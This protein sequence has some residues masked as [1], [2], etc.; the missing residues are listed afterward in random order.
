MP[1]LAFLSILP[2]RFPT[3]D[4]FFY[5]FFYNP[6]FF[7]VLSLL[8]CIP[9][10]TTSAER[11]KVI[12]YIRKL[13]QQKKT[14]FLFPEGEIIKEKNVKQLKQGI[15]FFIKDASMVM[16]VRFHGLNKT[17]REGV[18]RRISFGEV[19]EPPP[20]MTVDGM[21]AYLEDL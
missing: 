18:S 4:S 2:I 21:R 3:H 6:R 11:M 7:P 13:L 17:F 15:D 10:G 12:F 14:V 9:V 1:F 5:S 19:F 20:S 8:G 16:F